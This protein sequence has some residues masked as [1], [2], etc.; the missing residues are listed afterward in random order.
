MLMRVHLNLMEPWNVGE[1]MAMVNEIYQVDYLTL[2]ISPLDR[3]MFASSNQIILLYVG[4]IMITDKLIF[5]RIFDRL[6]LRVLFM[7]VQI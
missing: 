2:L 3:I 5:H 7:R 1:I 4:E 6:R